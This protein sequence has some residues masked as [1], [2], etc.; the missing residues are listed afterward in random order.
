[1]ELARGSVTDR[2][3]GRTLAALAQRALTGELTVITDGKRYQIAFSEGTIV[4]AASPLAGDAAV[5]IALTAGLISST[6]VSDIARRQAANPG[7]DEIDLLAEAA[8]LG[9][10]HTYRLRRRTIAQ[11]AA[12]TFSLDRGEFVVDDEITL[13]VVDG[14]ALDIRTV[15]YLG[16]KGN[17]SEARLGHDLPRLGAW[18]RLRPEAADDLPFFGFGADDQPALQLLERGAGLAEL[19]TTV[20]DP[21]SVH[22]VLYALVSCG[23]VEAAAAPPSPSGLDAPTA[24]KPHEPDT[25]R[26]QQTQRFPRAESEATTHR[27]AVD[28]GRLRGS[29]GADGRRGE[30]DSPTIQRPRS[31]ARPPPPL[32]NRANDAQASD[33]LALIG[34]RLKLLEERADHFQLLGVT[35]E[36][37]ANGLRKAY[38]SL[39]KQLHPDRLASLGIVDENRNAQRLFAEV[40]AAFAV[41]NDPT[42]RAEYTAILRRG[43]ADAVRAE[44]ARAEA[45]A[46]RVIDSEEA[47]RRGEL[48]LKRDQLGTAI[49][50]LTRAIE[51]NPDEADYHSALAWAHFCAAPDKMALAAKTRTDL[52]RAIMRSP[53]AVMGRF[54]LGRVERMLGKDTEALALFQEVV[55]AAPNHAEAKAEIR[56]LE[57]RLAKK[58]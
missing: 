17:L 52:N 44:D 37:D 32:K 16:A 13:P 12:R 40:N 26:H 25:L 1:V 41:L 38:F 20:I 23:A 18:F 34:E 48:A 56:V 46:Q 54:Y 45:L 47:F 51:L 28:V 50:E 14:T 8:R 2:P 31:A 29:G 57:Q 6:Q 24:R 5:R 49:A 55:R 3:W 42:R 39:A 10:D 36:V 33:I 15:V 22:A 58:R 4:A 11:R 43:G 7:R 19:E 30:I 35:P 9:P 21:R 53:R 27:G